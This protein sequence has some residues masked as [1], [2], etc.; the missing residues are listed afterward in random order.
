MFYGLLLGIRQSFSCL[1]GYVNILLDT[2][3]LGK[4]LAYT[5]RNTKN[6]GVFRGILAH[7]SRNKLGELLVSKGYISANELKT[8]LKIQKETNTPFGQVCLD[9]SYIRSFDLFKVLFCQRALRFSA[10]ALLSVMSISAVSKRSYA[11]QIADVPAKI[12]LAS[13][14]N[15]SFKGLDHYPSLFGASEK[16]SDNLKAFTKWSGMFKRFDRA[17]GKKSSQRIIDNMKRELEGYSSRSVYQMAKNV[18]DM[19]NKKRY[20][21]DKN[22]WGK[23][24][25]WATPIEFMERGGDC[26]DFAIAKYSA[27]RALGVPEER[28]R[29][30]IVQDE[31]KNIPH[32][33]LIVYSEKGPFVLDNQIKDMRAT[34]KISHYKPIFSINREAWWLH[35]LPRGSA[36]TIVASAN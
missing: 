13:T 5:H 20:I 35:S 11:G 28:L 7:F 16:R 19:M 8:I 34:S 33:I 27:L 18:N 36:T 9:H 32:A 2:E 15:A 6:T 17:L 22:N 12:S 14:A 4:T 31:I 24:D 21:L 29:I 10:A 3:E 30:A 26:E 23:S 1:I 25:Y